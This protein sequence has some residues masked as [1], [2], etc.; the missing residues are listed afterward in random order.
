M[1]RSTPAR[2][3]LSIAKALASVPPLTKVTLPALAPTSAATS[4]LAASISALA[5]RPPACTDDG[6]PPSASACATA[7]AAS[8]RTFA[9]AL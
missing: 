2:T 1:M 3:A 8:D 6:L 4:A 7:A 9:V 5:A